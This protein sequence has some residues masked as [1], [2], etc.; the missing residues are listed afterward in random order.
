[1]GCGFG[2]RRGFGVAPAQIGLVTLL[3][4]PSLVAWS[5]SVLKEPAQLFLTSVVC[6]GVAFASCNAARSV[7]VPADVTHAPSPGVAS[8]SSR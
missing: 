6:A 1:M 7:H 3:F 4:W 8:F 5:V 2:V